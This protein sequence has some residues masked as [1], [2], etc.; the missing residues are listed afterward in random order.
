M[1]PLPRTGRGPPILRGLEGPPNR[2]HNAMRPLRWAREGPGMN[3]N[4]V[5]L[6]DDD[7]SEDAP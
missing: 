3:D 5:P 4:G 2:G 1:R 7:D 6:T